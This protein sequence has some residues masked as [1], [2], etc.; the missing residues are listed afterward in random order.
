VSCQ[1]SGVL[2]LLPDAATFGTLFEKLWYCH[3][4]GANVLLWDL[5]EIK[6]SWHFFAFFGRKCFNICGIFWRNF[7]HIFWRNLMYAL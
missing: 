1:R 2:P 3:F 5:P 6:T 4:C 7:F